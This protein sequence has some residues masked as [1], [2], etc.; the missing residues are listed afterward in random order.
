MLQFFLSET[1]SKD[2][3]MHLYDGVEPIFD[4]HARAM[5]WYAHRVTAKRRKCVIVTEVQSRYTLVFCG[6][7]KRDFERFPE[8]F[9]KRLLCEVASVCQLDKE[10]QDKLTPLVV[11]QAEQQIYQSGSISEIVD[12]IDDVVRQ[13][14]DWVG[15][16]GRL[17]VDDSECFDF[18]LSVNQTRR[19]RDDES[20]DF[21]P[22]ERFRRFWSGLSSFMK[23]AAH[24][25]QGIASRSVPNNILPFDRDRKEDQSR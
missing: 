17:P 15:E 13:L 5:Q 14:D 4:R 10:A 12:H 18:G 7:T 22:L 6:L 24:R 16:H 2:L 21:E 25:R 19:S 23:F 1:F 20:T 11:A 8:L 3:S 9:R